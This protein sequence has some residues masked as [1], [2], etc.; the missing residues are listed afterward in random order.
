M[1]R[2]LR[3]GAPADLWHGGIDDV[4]VYAR[5]LDASQIPGG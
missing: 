4:R 3:D 2:G 5:A 1:G